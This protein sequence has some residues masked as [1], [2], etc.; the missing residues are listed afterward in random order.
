MSKAQRLRELVARRQACI[1]ERDLLEQ[2]RK[3]IDAELLAFDLPLIDIGGVR[4]QRCRKI[5]RTYQ[6][7]PTRQILQ[8]YGL[9][10][11]MQ[12]SMPGLTKLLQGTKR[13]AREA[14]RA[15]LDSAGEVKVTTYLKREANS[16]E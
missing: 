2:E 11:P 5:T 8:R 4:L 13:A 3:Q 6:L 10:C 9:K 7:E 16:S 12:L 14:I 15:E 1:Q